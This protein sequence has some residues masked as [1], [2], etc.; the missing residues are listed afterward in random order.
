MKIK[1]KFQA[2]GISKRTISL[3]DQKSLIL[4]GKEIEEEIQQVHF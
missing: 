3:E 1:T 4:E 2:E